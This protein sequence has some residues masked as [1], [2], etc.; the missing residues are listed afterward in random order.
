MKNLLIVT[1]LSLVFNFYA[2][3]QS[4]IRNGDSQLSIKKAK[5]KITL[6]GILDEADW[7]MAEMSAP[8]WQSYPYDT[9]FSTSITE[10]RWVFDDD[11]IYVSAKCYEK[12]DKYVVLSLKRDF[13]PGT[14]DL[15]AVII[16]PFADGQ[17]AFSF[18]VSPLGV[19]REGLISNGNVFSTDWDNKWFSVVKNYDD[20]WTVE[21]AIPFKTIRYKNTTD[22]N[23][24]NTNIEQK[25]N[26]IKWN[27]NMLR[28]DQSRAQVERSTC[29]FCHAIPTA[30]ILLFQAS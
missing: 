16:D 10:T 17:N 30:I 19:Q 24:V 2:F 23:N 13:G 11:N 26:S 14:T 5:G 18:S 1:S 22:E 28:F 9:T 4:P 8:F 12:K 21:M 29:H 20:Y 7:Q 6:D 25:E 27:I 3:S 15:F